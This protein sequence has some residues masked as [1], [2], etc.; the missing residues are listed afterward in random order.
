M[1]PPLGRPAAKTHRAAQSI[2][3]R[4]KELAPPLREVLDLLLKGKSNREMAD[5][6]GIS[7]RSI[8]VRRSKVMER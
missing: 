2:R 7:V 3:R 8:E 1:R 6:L 4:L 5:E